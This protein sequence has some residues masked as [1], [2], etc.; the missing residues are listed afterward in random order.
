[1]KEARLLV[2]I[3]ELGVARGGGVELERFSL[4]LHAG[5]TVVLL[6]EA[7]SGKDAVLRALDGQ[8]ERGEDVSGTIRFGEGEARPAARKQRP[9]LRT[10]FLPG[11]ASHP[12]DG[13][14]GAASQLERVIAR[15]LGCPRGGAREELRNA[16]ARFAGAPSV[17]ALDAPAATLD[18][19]TVAWGLLAAAI[20]TTPELLLCDHPFADLSPVAA[21]ALSKALRDEQARL[22]FA[23]VYAARE[24]QPVLRLGGR[25]LVLRQGRVVEEGDT[26]HL[27]SGQTHAYTQALFKALPGAAPARPPRPASRGEPLLQVQGLVLN[28]EP[29]KTPRQRDLLGFELRRG[30]S[31]ALLGEA[32][33]GRHTLLRALLGLERRPGRILF[34]AVDLNLLSEAM[35]LR[36]RRRVAFITA[37][38]DALDPRMT[39]WDTVDEPL[40]AHLR[41]SREL[42]AGYRDTALKRVGLAS[43]DGRRPVATLSP[44]DKRR[45]QVAR[46]I[47]GAPLLVVVDEPLRGL[48]AVAQ[49]TMRDLLAE[50]RVESQ[51]A[52]L[53]VTSD[54]A[55]AQALC[56]DAFVFD[57]GRVVERGALASLVRAPKD[58]ATKALIEAVAPLPS[59]AAEV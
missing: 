30:A 33:S 47:V 6:G 16:L 43:H 21:A 18:D 58:E 32:G 13:Q 48:D 50:F 29:R 41:L 39:L 51:A 5:E 25:T 35:T 12:L 23:I 40:R 3:K 4:A 7:G 27:V 28:P 11:A 54:F 15:K 55:V 14:A 42:T 10:A 37:D 53:V 49:T 22:G 44:F 34:D 24:P 36:L 26:A 57:K 45:L 9:P 46:A 56:D 20:A 31:L 8:L 2:E 19:A 1:M 52:F 17:E 59:G 38:D